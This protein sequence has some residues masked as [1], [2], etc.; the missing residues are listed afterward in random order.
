MLSCKLLGMVPES[1]LPSVI[2][3]N[4]MPKQNT[5][6]PILDFYVSGNSEGLSLGKIKW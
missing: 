1:V 4:R 2:S 5:L 6:Q 3:Q